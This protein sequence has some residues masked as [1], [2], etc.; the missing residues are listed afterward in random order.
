MRII[1]AFSG[2]L[3]LPFLCFYWPVGVLLIVV[4]F[5]CIYIADKR[6]R[7]AQA[8]EWHYQMYEAAKRNVDKSTT[9]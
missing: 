9:G 2:L 4:G 7:D 1:G 6:A 5:M 8:A 3:G